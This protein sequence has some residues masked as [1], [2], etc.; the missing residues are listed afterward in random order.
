MVEIKQAG[1]KLPPRQKLTLA[2]WLQ[3]QVCDRLSEGEM[4]TIASDGAQA[5]DK[6][7][8]ACAKR[9]TR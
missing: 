7:E 6:R 3:A 2:K 4:M 5:L 8:A 1:R 9:K